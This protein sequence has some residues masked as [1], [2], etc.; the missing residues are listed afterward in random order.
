MNRLIIVLFFLAA[1]IAQ[2][3]CS[4]AVSEAKIQAAQP[5][6]TDENS[7]DKSNSVKKSKVAPSPKPTPKKILNTVCADPAKPCRHE[8]KEFDDW[9]LSF[10]MPARLI[11]NKTY[12]SAPFYAIIVK[13]YDEGCDEVGDANPSVEPERLKLQKEFPERKVFAE[14]SC[15]N[16][17][18]VNYDFAGRLDK[19][20][21]HDL[22]MDYI[23]VYAGSDIS[24]AIGLNQRLLAKFP[25]AEVKKMTAR[26]GIIEQ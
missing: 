5:T 9:E 15:P 20:G 19:S 2:T 23:A 11:P 25:Q 16:M 22:Y 12:Q 24:E 4:P 3:A 6:K 7:A 10:Q 18:A 8:Q 21:E 13:K 1:V 17:S 26:F 14:Y